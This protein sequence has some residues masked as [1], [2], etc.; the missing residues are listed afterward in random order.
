MPKST[1]NGNLVFGLLRLQVSLFTS[2]REDRISFKQ[3]CPTHH[4]PISQRRF[5]PGAP[6]PGEDGG[7]ETPAV[8]HEV[9][10]ASLVHGYTLG[11]EL[12]VF[13]SEE[14]ERA[15]VARNF[16]IELCVPE[17]SVDPRFYDKPYIVGPRDA[18]ADR[19]YA[20]LREALRRTGMVAIGKIALKSREQLAAVRVMGGILILHTMRWPAELVSLAE[21]A[22]TAE[23]SET[24]LLD[25]E[26]SM[27]E[28][29]I[30]NL[31]G[32]IASA[33]F[34]DE[35]QATVERMVRA[36]LNGEDL[37]PVAQ[38]EPEESGVADLLSLL[39]AS[40]DAQKA[41]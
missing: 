39:Q 35:Y 26:V 12:A 10:Y 13:T 34:R 32:S 22:E 8:S 19:P 3:L 25:A 40:L 37:G 16:D 41:A 33:D 7:P 28:Q 2:V 21:F 29:L 24:V 1:W 17:A 15:P 11:E 20:L 4:K 30:H 6:T 31:S 14:L 36:R 38:P 27:A 9:A 23:I 18:S 5:C